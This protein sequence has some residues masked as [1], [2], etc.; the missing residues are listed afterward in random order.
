METEQL[1]II[2]CGL[3]ALAVLVVITYYAKKLGEVALVVKPLAEMIIN[4]ADVALAPYGTALAP[5]N[6]AAT[7]IGTLIDDDTDALVK[8]LPPDVV[9]ALR[10]FLLYAKT[11]TDGEAPPLAE[12]VPEK[13]TQ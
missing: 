6:T 4:R 12:S 8:A 13:G 11:L 10:I 5:V 3:V 9:Q 2:V 7:A 1:I